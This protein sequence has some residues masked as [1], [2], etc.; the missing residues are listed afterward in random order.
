MLAES[1]KKGGLYKESIDSY[2]NA[3]RTSPDVNLYII[4][5]NIYDEKLNDTKNA[6]RYYELFLEKLKTVKMNFKSEY[7]ESV[8]KRVQYLKDKQNGV[9]GK[10]QPAKLK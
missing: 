10:P 2:L 9:T 7:I 8:R 1:Q 4:I 3:L 6:I 5:A